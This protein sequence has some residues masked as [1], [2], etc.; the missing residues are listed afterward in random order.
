[1]SNMG[2]TEGSLLSS[3]VVDTRCKSSGSLYDC[4]EEPQLLEQRNWTTSSELAPI[5]DA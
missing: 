4:Q 3:V 1:M 5:T 2:Y